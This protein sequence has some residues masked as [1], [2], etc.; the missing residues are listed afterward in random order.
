MMNKSSKVLHGTNTN[1]VNLLKQ[2]SD[3]MLKGQ[4]ED[5][6]TTAFVLTSK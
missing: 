2:K 5:Y 6:L 1:A 3:I 4:L